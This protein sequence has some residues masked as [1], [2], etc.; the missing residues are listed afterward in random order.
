MTATGNAIVQQQAEIFVPTLQMPDPLIVERGEGSWV[1]DREGRRYLDLTSGLGSL[2]LG[3]NHPHVLDGVSREMKIF[4]HSG[5]IYYNKT[6]SAAMELLASVA[7]NGL[8]TVFLGNSRLETIETAVKLARFATGR[9]GV[10]AFSGAFHGRPL[11][12]VSLT[13]SSARFRAHYQPLL[14]SVFHAP[15]PYCYRCHSGPGANSCTRG[16]LKYLREMLRRHI[17]PTE[18][19]A[20]IIE[21]VLGEGGY[22]PAPDVFLKDLREICNEY[23][24]LLIFDEVQSAMGRTGDWFAAQYNDVIPDILIM[25]RGIASGFPLAAIATSKK[26]VE[27]W[28]PGAHGSTFSGNTVACAAAIA[29]IET[30]RDEG[31]LSRCRLLGKRVNVRLR[32]MQERYPHIGDVRRSGLMIGIELIEDDGSPAHEACEQLINYCRDQGLLIFNC[33]QD[34]NIIRLLPPLTIG[35]N[36]LDQAMEIIEEGLRMLEG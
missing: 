9:Q 28:S 1:V 23:G 4:T 30:I 10:I 15:Y 14:H 22:V 11:G 31:L 21:P 20:I 36:E 6:T 33:G 27:G 24:I 19:A 26:L 13:N 29:T 32:S 8:D 16:C 7:P 3:H 35:D 18:I 17:T 5:G 25:A 34:L 2:P 12:T